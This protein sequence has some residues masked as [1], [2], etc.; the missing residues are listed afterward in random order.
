[1]VNEIV[2]SALSEGPVPLLRQWVGVGL[3]VLAVSQKGFTR[4]PY[5]FILAHIALCKRDVSNW[6]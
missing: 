4:L 1:M 5:G 2:M 6:G 3:V